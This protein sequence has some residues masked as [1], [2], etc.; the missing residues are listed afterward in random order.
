MNRFTHYSSLYSSRE[1]FSRSQNS[2]NAVSSFEP[3]KLKL[4]RPLAAKSR[5]NQRGKLS[6]HAK[7]EGSECEL[8]VETKNDNSTSA[9]NCRSPSALREGGSQD[10]VAVMPTSSISDGELASL[11]SQSKRKDDNFL[12][13]EKRACI[14]LDQI[15]MQD[16]SDSTMLCNMN[17]YIQPLKDYQ[18]ACQNRA[19]YRRAD[20]IQQVLRRLRLDA[21]S[22]HMNELTKAQM[23]DREALEEL[24]RRDFREFHLLWNARIDEFEKRMMEQEIRLVQ[25]QN[26][27]MIKFQEEIRSSPP[28]LLRYS[29]SLIESRMRQQSLARQ[30]NYIFAAAE[31]RKADI[32][33]ALDLTR[34]EES[35]A[36]LFAHREQALRHHQD[37][38]LSALQKRIE[39]RRLLLERT[40]QQELEILL[41][42]YINARNEMEI[43]QGIVRSKTGLM[44]Q[45]HSCNMRV[46][47]SGNASLMESVESGAFGTIIKHRLEQAPRVA[48][49]K[50][51]QC[52]A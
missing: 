1:T 49:P 43:H 34:F 32:L 38:E 18:K 12:E 36:A 3:L 9:V 10:V 28:R 40:R 48:S 25:H 8:H 47:G 22:Y 21:E 11:S 35:K 19:M 46:D 27:K 13:I 44:L 14:V 42:R 6:N 2:A 33:D 51:E 39:S 37:Q 4:D 45:K 31:K 15:F 23:K 5:R 7:L 52:D 24:Y 26:D 17:Q 29:R 16:S 41:Q 30:E 20:L 50:I